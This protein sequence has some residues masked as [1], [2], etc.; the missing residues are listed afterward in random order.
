M[1]ADDRCEPDR[2]RVQVRYLDQHPEIALIGGSIATMD[3]TGNPLAPCVAFPQTHAQIWAG[4]GRLPWVFCNPAVMYHRAAAVD[5]GMYREEFAHAEDTEFFARLMARHQAVNLPDVLL[6]YRLRRSSVSFTKTAHG[7]INAELVA[8]IIDR[9]KPGEPFEATPEERREADEA[10]AACG[11]PS[12]VNR[13]ESAYHC[14]V[15]RELLRG[16]QWRRALRHYAAA[17]K[18]DWQN[19]MAYLGIACSLLHYGAE[20]QC[21]DQGSCR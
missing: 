19:R 12:P 1:D 16:R 4:I 17:A 11:K 18:S 2:F 14:R 13:I 20:P 9:W 8:K 5:V 15:G 7:R 3:E 6:H 21:P 10:I